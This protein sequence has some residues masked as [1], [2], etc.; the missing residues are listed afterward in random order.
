VPEVILQRFAFGVEPPGSLD[1]SGFPP[2]PEL[3]LSIDWIDERGDVAVHFNARPHQRAIVLNSNV[4]GTWGEEV[5]VPEY[6]FSRDLDVPCRIRFDIDDQGFSIAA[7][8]GVLAELPHRVRPSLI[9]YVRSTGWLWRLEQAPEAG[10]GKATAPDIVPATHPTAWRE[11]WVEWADNPNE[12][13]PV[14]SFRLFAVI[15]TWM[16]E[17]VVAATIAHAKE[18]GCERVFL[19]DNGSSDRTV[20]RAIAAGAELA[21][22]FDHGNFDD[23]EK[24]RQMQLVVDRVS[25]ASADNHIWWL[26]LDADEF[27]HGPAGLTIRDYLATLDRRFRVVGARF[28]N[29]LP[30][31]SPAYVE[32][33]HPVEC[34]PLCYELPA[35]YC[36][37]GHRKHPLQRWDR[38]A[39]RIICGDGFHRAA[40]A[41]RIEE[42]TTPVFLHHFPFREERITSRRLSRLFGE[43]GQ[44]RD[45]IGSDPAL[46]HHR[47]RRASLDAVYAQ[48][49]GEIAYFP[50]CVRGYAP[51]LRPFED[52]LVR[53]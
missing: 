41:D 48:R 8:A 43:S 5:V 7:G 42:P 32:G 13:E 17:D 14:P 19:V 22:R 49:W 1:L 16:E 9:R 33:A 36:E 37:L 35:W 20:D 40:C 3:G 4:A 2:H 10:P 23:T 21:V 46:G 28:F 15:C 52:W 11:S 27:H 30:D 53:K 38:T 45:R 31:R 29:H 51:E 25:R 26:W 44:G 6:P 12:P 34:Q 18:Q 24:T 47:L 50:P 39:S